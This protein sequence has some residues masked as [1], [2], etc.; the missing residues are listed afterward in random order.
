MYADAYTKY[1]RELDGSA[2]QKAR[3]E[4]ETKLTALAADGRANGSLYNSLES[5]AQQLATFETLQASRARV[6]RAAEGASQ[7]SPKATLNTMLGLILG[8]VLGAGLAFAAEALDTR[9]RSSTAVADALD[10][11][12]L[13]RLPEP[14]R[15]IVKSREL[16][17]L[18]QPTGPAA[19]AFRMLRTNLDFACL[20]TEMRSLLVASAREGE[21]KSTTAAN[22]AIALARAGKSV[23]L[24][25]LD[26][27]KPTLDKLFRLPTT[28]GL[29]D[30]ALRRVSLDEAMATIDLALGAPSAHRAL[31]QRLAGEDAG[32]L[33]VLPAGPLPPDPG[34]FVGTPRMSEILF[35]LRGQADIVLLD[36]APLMLV[37]DALTLSA[38]VD[39][40]IVLAKTTTLRRPM[41]RELKRLL[42]SMPTR[43]LGL[44]ITGAPG[45]KAEYGYGYGYGHGYE[46]AG[47]GRHC[48]DGGEGEGRGDG[49][50]QLEEPPTAT[51]ANH[52]R[53]PEPA[54]GPDL[55]DSLD[56]VLDERTY[57]LI[58]ERRESA[59]PHRRGW[60]VRRALATADVIG[61]F[62][63]FAF[64]EAMFPAETVPGELVTPTTELIAFTATLPLWIVL[65]KL[66]G[67][68]D[69]DEER[70][71]HSTVDDVV[72]VFN[73]VTT[74]MW[75]TTAVAFL[76]GFARPTVGKLF[77]FWVAAVLARVTRARRSRA[78]SAAARRPT[79]RTR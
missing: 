51:T 38:K 40:I 70:A 29:T 44:V 67:L 39:G 59:H 79:P 72:G 3:T 69:R 52:W 5:K 78:A 1:R 75:V 6:V 60:L 35:E 74:G 42:D 26:L 36:S 9:V 71:D 50:T 24:V 64:A 10:L 17:M 49:V 58:R 47:R 28:P 30:V 57:A 23:V 61:L 12:L 66:Y 68:Y 54:A 15:N 43:K 4:V 2:I 14:P 53:V 19:E 22:L 13:A 41:L 48:G 56:N 11:Q 27:R 8:L 20:D 46:Q 77:L 33:R 32:L 18:A 63:A 34:E 62:A 16:V 76:T 7:V 31:G 45:G 37:G 65:A 21:G 25:D 73:M 55:L